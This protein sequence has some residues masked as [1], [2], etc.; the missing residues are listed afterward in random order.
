MQT[1]EEYQQNFLSPMMSF[2]DGNYTGAETYYPPNLVH[3]PPEY[4]DRVDW[5]Q[6]GFVTTVN[7]KSDLTTKILWS[8]LHPK[9]LKI[10]NN[11]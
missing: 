8:M 10:M 1:H 11:V 7:I 4:P 6:K 5:R 3:G 9:S 2:G